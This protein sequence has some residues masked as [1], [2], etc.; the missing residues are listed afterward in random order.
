MSNFPQ[1]RHVLVIEDQKARRIISLEEQTYSIGRESTN[2]IVIYDRVVSRQHATLLKI[3][4]TPNGDHYCYRIVD[5]DLE[6]NRSTNGLIINGNPRE[7]HDL[8]HGDVVFFGGRARASYYILSNAW[9]IGLFNPDEPIESEESIDPNPAG[10]ENYKSTLV[11]A[12]RELDRLD[13]RDL[14]RLASFPEL[15]PNPIVEI[16]FEGRLIYL[17]PAANLKFPTLPQDALAHPL[18]R[19]LLENSH[20]T[21]GSLLLREIIVNDEVFEQYVH[22]LSENRSIRSYIFDITERKRTEQKL[23]YQAF[24]DPLT[25]L[26]NRTCFE[27]QLAGAIEQARAGR[28]PMAVLFLDMDGFKNVNDSLGHSFGD[29]VLQSFARRIGGCLRS[30]DVFARWG[31]DEFTI[32]LH[33]IGGSEEALKLAQR[34]SEELKHPFDIQEQRLYMKAS[35]GIAVYPQ[36]GEDGESLLKNADAALYRAKDTG[37]DR[38]QFYRDTMTSKASL[39]L[40]LETLLHQALSENSIDLHYQPRVDLNTGQITGMEALFRWNHPEIGDVSIERLLSL[41]EQTDLGVPLSEWVLRTAC[42]QNRLWQESGLLPVP[43]AVNF[44]PRQFQDP[45]L[46][47]MVAEILSTT[48]LDPSLLEIEIAETSILQ[49]EIIA[50]STLA[51]LRELGV[52]L[53]LDDF[54]TGYTALNYLQKFPFQI[55]KLDRGF[56]QSLRADS[57]VLAILSALISLGKNLHLR[58]VAEG[59]ETLEQLEILQKLNC[60]EAQGFWFSR[61]LATEDATHLLQQQCPGSLPARI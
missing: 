1:F 47:A 34:I 50:G 3:K 57:R 55:V 10:G 49:D 13:P 22:Y 54:G 23:K 29:L 43:I 9:E 28:Y 5:G 17:N 32:L 51:R 48:G 45:G 16:G 58:V 61:P 21:E 7:S 60:E 37:R 35:L 42:Q 56:I 53:A 30:G 38:Y 4:K 11:S 59:I 26:P 20:N 25:G 46:V 8:K 6:G 15:S 18:I 40:K 33:R 39:M 14:L 19:G 12:E 24:H 27:R 31:G 52:Q 44:S 2:E 36:D 41:V